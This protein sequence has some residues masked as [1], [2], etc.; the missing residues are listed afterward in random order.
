MKGSAWRLRIPQCTLISK[1]STANNVLE[2]LGM[3]I[4]TWIMGE[5]AED[6]EFECLLALGDN[7]SALGWIHHAGQL[8]EGSPYFK[9]IQMMARKIATV[10]SEHGVCLTTQH[11]K[12]KKNLVADWL[13]YDGKR[14]GRAH[15][16]AAD[17]PD[18]ETLTAR[19]HHHC[20]QL[21]PQDFSISRLTREKL[22]WIVSVLRTLESSLAAESKHKRDA[23][24]QL[25]AMD[26]ILAREQPRSRF[27]R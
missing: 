17:E 20:P 9:D 27:V 13:S 14:D 7:T 23:R 16:L 6:G 26:W 3:A 5:E 21:I 1:G 18:D 15:T 12:G 19:F 11:I 2:F 24:L 10:V 8:D 4:N 22:S 25:E